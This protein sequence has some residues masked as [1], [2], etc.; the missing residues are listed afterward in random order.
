[1]DTDAM[2]RPHRLSIS[3]HR[4]GLLQHSYYLIT[5]ELKV[6]RLVG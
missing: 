1:M 5:V 4:A 6:S 3:V 2:F